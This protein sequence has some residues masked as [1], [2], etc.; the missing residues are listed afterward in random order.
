[1]TFNNEKPQSPEKFRKIVDDFN[2]YF[3]ELL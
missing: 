1:M 2:E 3:Q